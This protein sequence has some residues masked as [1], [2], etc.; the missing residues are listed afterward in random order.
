MHFLDWGMHTLATERGEKGVVTYI[1]LTSYDAYRTS[2]S[3]VVEYRGRT[4]LS[5]P[6]GYHK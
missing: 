2:N 1:T 3:H 4:G 6:A 5:L